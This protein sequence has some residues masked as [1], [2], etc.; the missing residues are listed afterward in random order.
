VTEDVLLPGLIAAGFALVHLVGAQLRFLRV[1]PRSIWLSIAGGVSV[2]YVFVHLLP[3]LADQQ[4][5]VSL[6][7]EGVGGLAASIE[8]HVYLVA[9]AGLAAFYGLE[10]LARRTAQGECEAG[11]EPRPPSGVFWIHLVSF[12]FYNLV[13]GYL[14]VH[15]EEPGLSGLAAYAVA[16]GLH[17]L[18]NDQSLREHHG[19]AYDGA[20]RWLLAAAPV[21]GWALGVATEISDLLLFALFAFLAGGVILNVLKEELPEDRESRFWAFAAGAGV[22]SVLLLLA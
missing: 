17:F 2:A 1:T 11:R 12:A 14:L 9:L 6:N 15:R 20:G 21:A 19:R 10:H 8:S 5:A 16:M 3:E 4:R 22:Y 18:V 7:M 13:I